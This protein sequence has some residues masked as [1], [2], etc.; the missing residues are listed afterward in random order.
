M[1]AQGSPPHAPSSRDPDGQPTLALAAAAEVPRV[2]LDD[3]LA[4]CLLL[5]DREPARYEAAAVRWTGRLCLE[6]RHVGLEEL[7]MLVAALSALCGERA[8]VAATALVALCEDAW[9]LPHGSEAV[10]RWRERRGL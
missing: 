9:R 6:V 4:L 3:A 10:E 2:G 8:A 5:L 7:G 1:T